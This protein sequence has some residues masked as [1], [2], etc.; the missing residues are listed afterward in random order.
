MPGRSTVAYG[1]EILD[2]VFY[3]PAIT[4]PTLAANTSATNT[5]TVPGGAGIQNVLPGDFISA[6]LQNPTAHLFLENIYCSAPGVLTLSWTTDS[7]GVTGATVGVVFNVVRFENVNM[8]GVLAMP[9]A[10]G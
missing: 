1:N 8:G 4:F 9:Q 6:N 5:F 7:S 10:F 3:A 2:T